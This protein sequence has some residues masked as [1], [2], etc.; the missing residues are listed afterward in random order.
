M[1]K[2]TILDSENYIGRASI[3]GLES[4][5]SEGHKSDITVKQWIWINGLEEYIFGSIYNWN[6]L[7]SFWS[8]LTWKKIVMTHI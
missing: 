4:N 8:I 5:I 6:F 7:P 3:V 2:T 1:K